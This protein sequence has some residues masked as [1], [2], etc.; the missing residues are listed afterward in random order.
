MRFLLFLSR[1]AAAVNIDNSE[2]EKYNI[3]VK[4]KYTTKR[5]TE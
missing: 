4:D 3:V 1:F 5:E 2:G